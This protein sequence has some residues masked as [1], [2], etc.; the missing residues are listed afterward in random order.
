MYV[1]NI[2]KSIT[3]GVLSY[4]TEILEAYYLVMK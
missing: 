1:A 3:R 2:V 4:N